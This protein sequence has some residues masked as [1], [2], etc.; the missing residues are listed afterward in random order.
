[1]TRLE[2]FIYSL[3]TIIVR[4]HDSQSGVTRVIVESNAQQLKIKSRE[5]AINGFKNNQDGELENQ[6]EKL[7][8]ECTL[9]YP[10][11]KPFL[12]FLLHQIQFLKSALNRTSSFNPLT[13]NA[14]KNQITQCLYDLKKLL[15]TIKNVTYKV[16]YSHL[17][18]EK[19]S[20]SNPQALVSLS[21]LMN[22]AYIGNTLCNSG[23]LLKE[24]IFEHFNITLDPTNHDAAAFANSL[25]TEHQ[26]VLLI[27]EL[28][29]SNTSLQHQHQEA[30]DKVQSLHTQLA[31]TKETI[32]S[33]NKELSTKQE[34][35]TQY[36]AI[37]KEQTTTPPPYTPE[38][39]G[40]INRNRL[41]SGILKPPISSYLVND[42]QKMPP[43]Q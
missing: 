25:C 26:N 5:W 10:A 43:N 38:R 39:F 28:I 27:P 21:G 23:L 17:N 11:R 13:L 42:S 8:A 12:D 20:E 2:E 41:F 9:G 29:A 6:L 18:A 22:D 34:A 31:L 35:I 37:N 24:E 32:D 7:I 15:N 16:H 40:I 4:Y 14:Y 19:D 33:L 30:Q 3:T 1:M 36:E